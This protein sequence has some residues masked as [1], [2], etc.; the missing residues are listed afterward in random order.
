MTRALAAALAVALAA[1]TA[2]PERAPP[3]VTLLDQKPQRGHV[4]VGTV[5]A[6]G[7][8]GQPLGSVYEVLRESAQELGADAVVALEERVRVDATPAPYDPPQRPLIGNAYPGP[9]QDFEPGAFP[10]E[11]SRVRS[12]G[13]YY[14][15][16]GLAI[17]FTN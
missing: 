8:P 12:R 7:Y 3:R 16:E 13:E 6:Q 10:P 2:A 4:V 5:R 17:R 11:G 1:C 9:L 15:V 14:V